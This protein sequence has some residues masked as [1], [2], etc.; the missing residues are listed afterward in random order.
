MTTPTSTGNP[1]PEPAAA[2]PLPGTTLDIVATGQQCLTCSYLLDGQPAF[3][4]EDFPI[5][6]TRCPECGLSQ[7]VGAERRW[8]QRARRDTS[9]S[10]W[11]W[12][13]AVLFMVLCVSGTV[14]GLSQ[15]TGYAAVYPLADWMAG[16]NT[17]GEPSRWDFVGIRWWEREGRDALKAAGLGPWSLVD[18]WVLTDLLW[19]IPIGLVAGMWF[20]A[21]LM[22]ADRR[23]RMGI[24]TVIGVLSLS[25]LIGYLVATES[26]IE[27]RDNNAVDLA[28][29]VV[30]WQISLGAWVVTWGTVTLGVWSGRSVLRLVVKHLGGLRQRAWASQLFEK[31]PDSVRPEE[32]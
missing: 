9:R 4:R 32:Y 23:G 30:G 3:V 31:P 7:P 18:W 14:F 25:G 20:Q 17:N 15:S 22:H 5:V 8:A 10:L 2:R 21:R 16:A 24:W 1:I 11:R 28:M 12:V 26:W 19:A 27:T 29:S 6:L 13:L